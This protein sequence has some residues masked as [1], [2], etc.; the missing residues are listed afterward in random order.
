M[1]RDEL[2][3]SD[4]I[5]SR[6]STLRVHTNAHVTGRSGTNANYRTYVVHSV[7]VP[8]CLSAAY[9]RICIT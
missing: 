3:L 1:T 6:P 4:S 2:L 5:C 8:H 7:T 9:V